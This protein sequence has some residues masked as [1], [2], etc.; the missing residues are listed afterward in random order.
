MFTVSL[1][2]KSYGFKKEKNSKNPSVYSPLYIK[3][4]TALCPPKLQHEGPVTP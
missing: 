4:L 3:I 1:I 2:K